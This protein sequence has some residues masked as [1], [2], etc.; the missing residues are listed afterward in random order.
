MLRITGL[1]VD[2]AARGETNGENV[3]A[4]LDLSALAEA[5][6]RSAAEDRP[7]R[8]ESLRKMD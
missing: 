1:P 4:A 2:L 3:R 5:A 7:V 6:N 8:P